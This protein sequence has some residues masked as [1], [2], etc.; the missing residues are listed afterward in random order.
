MRYRDV[1]AAIDWLC[2]T[3][4]L[5]Q[6]VIARG[7]NGE[8]FYAQ[9]VHGSGMIMVGSEDDHNLDRLVDTPDDPAV[10]ICQCCYLVVDDIDA[11]YERTLSAKAEIILPLS[12]DDSGGRGYTCRDPYGHVWNFG[13]FDPWHGASSTTKI[14]HTKPRQPRRL[15]LRLATGLAALSIASLVTGAGAWY[16]LDGEAVFAEYLPLPASSNFDDAGSETTALTSEPVAAA[17]KQDAIRT[18]LRRN[19]MRERKLRTAAQA[20]IAGL[21]ESVQREMGR[22][23]ALITQTIAN[24]GSLESGRHVLL[25]DLARLRQNA[26]LKNRNIDTLRDRLHHVTIKNIETTR[27]LQVARRELELARITNESLSGDIAQVQ[28]KIENLNEKL[29]SLGGELAEAQAALKTAEQ[30]E[31]DAKAAEQSARAALASSKRKT[32]RRRR[33][34]VYKAKPKKPQPAPAPLFS[35]F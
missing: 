1:A 2:Q 4:G 6:H 20:E 13:T 32:K 9:L 29:Q 21:K 30:A 10:R 22:H 27:A 35:P 34:K 11:H 18:S 28:Q 16:L 14:R 33:K 5:Q 7:P 31:Q 8:I 19:L 26:V 24:D 15:S 17:N 12:T 3:F 23:A 25:S